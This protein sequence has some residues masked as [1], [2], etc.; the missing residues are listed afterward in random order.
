MLARLLTFE[1]QTPSDPHDPKVELLRETV[2]SAPGYVAGFHLL[3]PQT[4]KGY[5]LIVAQDESGMRTIGKALAARTA[6]DRI[7]IDPDKTENLI[8]SAF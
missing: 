7:G 1:S 5:S 6:E 4:G 3:D 2:R 8:A